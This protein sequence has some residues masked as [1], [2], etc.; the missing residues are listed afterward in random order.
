M[1]EKDLLQEGNGASRREFLKGAALLS[2]GLAGAGILSGCQPAATGDTGTESPAATPLV[3]SGDPNGRVPGYAGPGDWLGAAPVIPDSDITETIESDLVLLGSG[4]S[5][6]G[7]VF[8]AVDEGLSVSVIER[9]PWGAFVDLEGT[10]AN[11]GGWYG[12]DIGHVNSK[13]LID[14]GYGPFNTGE[15]TTEFV[16]R[17]GGRV[18]PDIIKAF[19]QNSGPMFDRY[20]EIYDSYEAE[21]KADDGDVFLVN[22][23]LGAGGEDGNYDMSEMFEYPLCNTQACADDVSYPTEGGGYKSWPCNAQFY[24]Y[25]VN[26]I[27]YVHKYMVRYAQDN[28][29]QYFWE[30]TGV[31]LTQDSSGAV[32]GLIAQDAEGNYKKF[33]ARKAVLLAAGDY[34]GNP[35]MCWALLNEGM[36]WAERDGAV[37]EEWTSV[38]L[39]DGSGHRM[40]CWAG[41]MIEPSPRGWMGLSGGATGPW[42]TA[43]LLQLTKNGE[44]FMN[45][46]A[47]VAIQQ[48]MLRQPSPV[49]CWVSDAN[50]SKTIAQSP[51]DH[52]APNYGEKGWFDITVGDM[53][54][55]VPGPEVGTVRDGSMGGYT[56]PREVFCANT[57]DELADYLAFEGEAKTNFLE[58][59]KHYNELCSSAD[60]DTD[61]GKDK[62][63]MVA[64]DTPP[65]YGGAYSSWGG[66]SSHGM[67]PS[68]VTLSGL[69]TDKYQNVLGTDWEPIKGLYACGNCLG[70][71]YGLGYTTPFAG[72]S[73]GMA[74][75]HGYTASKNIAKL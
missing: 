24:G 32:T 22:V 18:N 21:R 71:R 40:A 26:N 17:S 47:V 19:I 28:G 35:D 55:L 31:V 65:Y 49:A 33:V 1:K 6:V 75:T 64:I 13:F 73:V 61:Y 54:A 56:R 70:G 3:P 2:A 38:G 23:G 7:A 48:A 68:M 63:Y 15:I 36:E 59:I 52:G 25:Q 12:E 67:T 42:G 43:P 34:I 39:R 66:G 27:E 10:G 53:N 45:E 20:K 60:G 62:K 8:S 46:A 30:H 9:Q 69:V 72:N 41:G 14:R 74:I 16:K 44:R 51:L 58:S 5:G 50:W 4:H 29:V 37:K 11:M 57:L